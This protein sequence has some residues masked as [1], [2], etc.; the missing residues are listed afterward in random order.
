MNKYFVLAGCL[1]TMTQAL[2]GEKVEMTK[3]FA[4]GGEIEISNMRGYVEVQGWDKSEV[5]VEG[6]LDDK[7]ERFIFE[8]KGKQAEIKV[9]M[10]SHWGRYN[11]GNNNGS[12]LIIKVPNKSDIEFEGVSSD[13]TAREI[14]GDI[15]LSSVSGDVK[16]ERLEGRV[17]LRSVSGS[18]VSKKSG[19]RLELEST[20]G[21]VSCVQCRGELTAASVSGDVTVELTQSSD[22]ELSAIS[23]DVEARVTKFS[24]G[25]SVE[26]SS[27]S[28]SV[29]FSFDEKV[30]ARFDLGTHAGGSISNKL[31]K[32]KARKAKYG[33]SSSLKFVKDGGDID[34]E[35]TTV[36]GRI[37]LNKL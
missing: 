26:A 11:D 36:S 27:V 29:S 8:V 3:P 10:P 21:D 30:S 16:S 7:A 33:P 31:T 23:G 13:V 24:R 18:I 9:K 2:A 25:A 15:E 1:M 5:S 35:V 20:S 4:P 12:R 17:D 37:K 32:D 6:E 14:S 34:V 19:G 22:L 28:G